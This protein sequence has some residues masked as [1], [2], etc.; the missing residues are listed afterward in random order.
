MF[1]LA[2]FCYSDSPSKTSAIT[3]SLALLRDSGSLS[4]TTA[5][6]FECAV[7]PKCFVSFPF[8]FSV[9]CLQNSQR[10]GPWG[11]KVVIYGVVPVGWWCVMEV[12]VCRA[13]I[14]AQSFPPTTC[15]SFYILLGQLLINRNLCLFPNSFRYRRSY[16]KYSGEGSQIFCICLGGAVGQG[17]V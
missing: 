3:F 1:S 9:T 15:S 13:L 10:C 17:A 12:Y 5:V 2:P 8:L 6:F 16:F 4:R 11:Y 14:L 7:V